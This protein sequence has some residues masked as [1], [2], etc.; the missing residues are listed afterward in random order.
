MLLI[1]ATPAFAGPE[2]TGRIGVSLVIPPRVE[3]APSSGADQGPCVIDNDSRE[4]RRIV[5]T[6]GRSLPRCNGPRETVRMVGDS[7]T[8]V[9]VTPV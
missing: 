9:V 7:R 1:L 3:I 4:L 8:R 6:S 5:D 2:A